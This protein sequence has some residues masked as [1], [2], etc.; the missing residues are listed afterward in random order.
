MSSVPTKTNCV[1]AMVN[2]FD[3]VNIALENLWKYDI[4]DWCE[5]YST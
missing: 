4:P 2:A 1:G 3:T 5:I